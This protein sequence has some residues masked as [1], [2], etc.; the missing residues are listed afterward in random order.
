MLEHHEIRSM[1]RHNRTTARTTPSQNTEKA[2]CAS[3]TCMFKS[4]N[5]KA[6]PVL[7]GGYRPEVVCCDL[8]SRAQCALPSRIAQHGCYQLEVCCLCLIKKWH[9][10]GTTQL[11]SR[12]GRLQQSANCEHQTVMD[13]LMSTIR[14]ISQVS[15]GAFVKF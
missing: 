9:K 5:Y 10:F 1:H 6:G 2:C 13:R 4:W 14:Y 3:Y 7:Q 11:A 12:P 8:I 15:D